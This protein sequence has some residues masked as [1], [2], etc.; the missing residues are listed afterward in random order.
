MTAASFPAAQTPDLEKVLGDDASCAQQLCSVWT[1]ADIHPH[2]PASSETVSELLRSGAG[3]DASP[4]HLTQWAAKGIVGEIRPRGDGYAW[5]PRNI[6]AAAVHCNAWRRFIPMDARH[7]HRLSAAELAE[8]Q[9]I[10]A[11]AGTAF[12][13]IDQFDCGQMVQMVER[14]EDPQIR[15]MLAIGLRAKLR[16][17]GVINQ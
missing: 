5:G 9:A 16:K 14:C 8:A 1:A 11:G 6:L 7:M 12:T 4:D 10:A 2:Y 15:H 17:L 3:F 13:D